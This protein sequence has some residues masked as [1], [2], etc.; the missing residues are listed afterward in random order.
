MLRPRTLSNVLGFLKLS[1]RVFVKYH[2][3]W[4]LLNALSFSSFSSSIYVWKQSLPEGDLGRN[5][6][7]HTDTL[8]LG[9]EVLQG[10]RSTD[11]W[12]SNQWA[13]AWEWPLLVNPADL[14]CTPL[15]IT[16]L[17][18]SISPRLADPAAVS[19]KVAAGSC[20]RRKMPSQ[21]E[22][23]FHTT[24]EWSLGAPADANYLTG[25]AFLSSSHSLTYCFV[26][27]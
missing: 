25:H 15:F 9:R 24:P 2:I 6:R 3:R 26:H 14:G 1:N 21:R 16:P 10:M 27:S 22:S 12:H 13:W 4:F 19:P 18:S 5:R 11:W 7:Q 20:K 23:M 8:D 17:Q